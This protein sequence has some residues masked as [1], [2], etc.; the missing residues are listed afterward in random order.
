MKE[1]LKGTGR[2]LHCER[3]RFS[4]R[5]TSLM[6]L[7]PYK[8]GVFRGAF[9]AVFRRVVCAYRRAE[10]ADCLLA[11]KCLYTSFFEPPPPPDYPDAG[12]FNQAPAPFVLNPPLTNR[13]A[14]HPND[15]LD[16]ELVLMG[17]AVEALP[18]FVYT[19]MELGR[20]GLGR[21]RGKYEL[22]RI[23]LLRGKE[24]IQV[25]DGGTQTLRAYP[26]ENDNLLLP[27]GNSV[28]A[29]NVEFLTPLRLKVKGDLVTKLDFPL[30][31]QRLAHRLGMLTAFYG[32]DSAQPDFSPLLSKAGDVKST[33]DK[34]F[35][36]D[37]VRYSGRQKTTMKFGGLRGKICFEGPLGPF[38]PYIRL[39]EQVNV[40]QGTSFGLG[41]YELAISPVVDPDLTG[42]KGK[43]LP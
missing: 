35:W 9:G 29:L 43:S 15:S 14:F 2:P 23:D 12:K 41:R 21:E 8:G 7:P 5:L 3:F 1:S 10:C 37:W 36:Y 32:T 24:K 38:M 19:F 30:F 17:P 26:P 40:G 22:T 28:G 33:S 27:E 4:L 39:G 42:Q 34:L 6:V 31:F 18:Y 16:F 20:Q 11:P 25:Y 13:Q